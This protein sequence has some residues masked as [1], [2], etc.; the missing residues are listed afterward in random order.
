MRICNFI[1]AYSCDLAFN[2]LFFTNQKISDKYHYKGDNL[3]LFSLINNIVISVISSLSSIIM[4]NIFQRLIDSRSS[5]E[6][7]FR[8]EEKKMGKNKNYKV[9]KETKIKVI[10]KIIDIS[11]KIKIKIIIF[12]IV[13]FSIMLFFYYFV[14]AFC[15]VYTK[16]QINW[17]SDCLSSFIISL[18]YEILIS[19]LITVLYSISIQYKVKLIYKIALFFYNL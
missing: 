9:S 13:E 12:I 10:N 6:D 15:E 16:T 7:I 4:V 5:F 8:K 14:T 17:L 3:L 18:F 11:L 2:T 1:F 19:L